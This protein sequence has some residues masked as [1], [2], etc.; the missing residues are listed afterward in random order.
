MI[1]HIFQ[2]VSN[3]KY[4]SLMLARDLSIFPCRKVHHCMNRYSYIAFSYTLISVIILFFFY[5][6]N[7]HVAH[8]INDQTVVQIK[9]LLLL[10][11][12]K[13]TAQDTPT[14]IDARRRISFFATSLFM[15]MPSAPKVCNML[16]FRLHFLADQNP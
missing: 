8:E 4:S 11:T 15:T 9:R 12:V 13:D 1:P 16:S 6:G 2:D 7:L 3:H 10:L 5:H 14:N